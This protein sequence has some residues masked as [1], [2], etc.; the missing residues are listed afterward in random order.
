MIH[1]LEKSKELLILTE[2]FQPSTGA[3]AQLV[4]DLV[5]DLYQAGVNV[6]VLTSTPGSP[7]QT[8]EILRF[9]SSGRSLIGIFGKLIAGLRFFVGSFFWLLL[10]ARSN[11]SVFIVSNPPFIG[12]V[13][14]LLYVIKRTPYVFLL[15]DVF[16]RSAS[17]T[18]VLPAKGPI[19]WS[20]RKLMQLVLSQSKSTVVLSQSMLKRCEKDFGAQTSLVSISNWSVL[21]PVST[22]K[23]DNPLAVAYGVANTFS[24]QYSGNFGRLHDILTLLEC[25]RLLAHQDIKLV[26]VGDGAKKTQILKYQKEYHLKNLSVFPYQT[27]KDLPHSL[28]A[29]D[30]SIVSLIPGAEDTV[31]P[32]K[33]YGILAS[34]KPVILIAAEDSE[35]ASQI[36]SAGCGLVVGNGDVQ[37]LVSAIMKLQG[38]PH[39]TRRMGQNSARLYEKSFGRSQS[40]QRYREIFEMHQMI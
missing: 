1:N 36:L 13:G 16:P 20:W 35:L 40:I 11:Q 30:V 27:R 34:A 26:V 7:G 9:T 3:T 19:M 10:N 12:L 39:L 6:R 2:H 32:S 28:A 23:Q 24:V 14:L 4:T 25:A 38:D 8:Y 21:T 18:G 29:C 33:F 17:L 37:G 22:P 5:D 15:Q 31:A